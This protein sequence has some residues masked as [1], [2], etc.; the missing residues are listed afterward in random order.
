MGKKL[1]YSERAQR[2]RERERERVKRASEVA[3]RRSAAK[4]VREKELQKEKVQKEAAL[5]TQ[6]RNAKNE[7]DAYEKF[8]S[9]ITN[10]HLNKSNI[11]SNKFHEL[12]GK[13][14]EYDNSSDPK[15][16]EPEKILD[17]KFEEKEY[18]Y[19]KRVFKFIDEATLAESNR[20]VNLTFEEYCTLE[21]KK[22]FNFGSWFLYF[23]LLF[24]IA[25]IH[26]SIS[27]K[28]YI[29][30]SEFKK[31]IKFHKSEI[32][33]LNSEK[34]IQSEK[35]SIQ[36]DERKLTEPGKFKESEEKRKVAE[37]A[38]YLKKK[39]QYEKDLAQYKIDFEKYTLKHNDLTSKHNI[40]EEAKLKW[41]NDLSNGNKKELEDILELLFPL[42]FTIDDEFIET[43]PSE[44]EVGYNVLNP[45]HIEV[46]IVVDK[47]LSFIPKIG[48]KLTATGKEVSEFHLTQK[49]Y[50]EYSNACISSLALIYIKQVFDF[51]N[52][53]ENIKIEICIPGTNKKTG[54]FEDEVLLQ[55]NVEK[56]VYK[57]LKY[58]NIDPIAAITNFPHAFKQFGGKGTY[59][60]SFIERENL[61]WSTVDDSNINLDNYIQIKFES[62]SR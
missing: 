24:P 23:L 19:K 51:C 56:N 46:I 38:A 17:Y 33:R 22:K 26:Y 13:I 41:Y 39:N 52:S 54:E 14:N 3:A 30:K 43:D 18:V 60:N 25:F 6:I 42:K 15:P 28:K 21:K 50:N 20:I 10:L 58:A 57:K 29:S 55:L 12:F 8:I 5:K 9:D 35:F 34:T 16:I 7:V 2:D 40:N 27:K 47:E 11:S 44:V 53:I 49:S 36:E 31:L 37:E 45:K 62:I 59:I 1:T 32:S 4:K 48:Y 61:L